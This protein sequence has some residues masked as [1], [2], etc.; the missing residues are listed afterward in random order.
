MLKII[1]LVGSCLIL[2]PYSLLLADTKISMDGDTA[3]G[4]LGKE[5]VSAYQMV[6]NADCMKAMVAC[7]QPRPEVCTQDYRPVCALLQDGSLKT[8]SNGC[9]ACSDPGVT[10]YHEGACE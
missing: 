9:S 4:Q 10:G 1:L 5:R 7:T 6:A 8:Y 3:A 2:F